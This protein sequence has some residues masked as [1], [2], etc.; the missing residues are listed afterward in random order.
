MKAI[1]LC[2]AAVLAVA[3]L[4]SQAETTYNAAFVSDYVWRGLTQTD[5]GAAFQAGA[6]YTVGNAYA[7]TWVSNVEEQD[8]AEGVPA[9]MDVYF[10]YN[11]DFGA[12]SIDTA[13]TTYNY[14]NDSTGDL[15]EFKVGVSPKQVKGLSVALHREVKTKYWYPEVAFETTLPHRLYLDAAAGYWSID[16]A[17]DSAF[18]MRAELARDFP[19]FHHI[20]VFGGLSYITDNTPGGNNADDDD[21]EALFLMGIR[22]NF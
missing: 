2:S 10:G 5:N 11:H 20:D 18:T 1:K 22:K 17:D 16:D 8:G 15:T 6:D 4:T 3:A 21:A 12:I 14:L 9:E 13:V 7:G 19:E